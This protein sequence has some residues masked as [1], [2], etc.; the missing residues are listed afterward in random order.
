MAIE[1]EENLNI[2]VSGTMCY[3]LFGCDHSIRV[4][5]CA[6][7]PVER[8]VPVLNMSMFACCKLHSE[9]YKLS[10]LGQKGENSDRYLKPQNLPVVKTLLHATQILKPVM[11]FSLKLKINW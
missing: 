6:L 4:A 11:L 9:D 1:I 5:A 7:K 2:Y 8:R 3:K 10:L